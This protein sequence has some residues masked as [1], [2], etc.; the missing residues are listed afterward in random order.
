MM[1]Y[2]D[3]G[4]GVAFPAG[5]AVEM[6]ASTGKGDASFISKTSVVFYTL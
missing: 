3:D 5:R 4:R 1:V 2:E 6:T